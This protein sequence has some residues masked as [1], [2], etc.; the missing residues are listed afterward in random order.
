[1]HIS[2]KFEVKALSECEAGKLIRPLRKFGDGI[3]ALV[4]NLEN[5]RRRALILL[6]EDGPVYVIEEHPDQHHVLEYAGGLIFELDQFGPYS[7][8][9]GEMFG[10]IGCVVLDGTRLLLNVRPG[11]I[12]FAFDIMHFNCQTFLLENVNVQSHNVAVFGKWQV[13]IGDTKRS[14]DEWVKMASFERVPLRGQRT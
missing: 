2:P 14:R 4:A 3:F 9:F 8:G 11:N 6:E 1:M 5:N 12:R 13:Y 10:E 7:S